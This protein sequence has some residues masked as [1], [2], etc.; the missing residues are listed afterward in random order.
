MER[1]LRLSRSRVPAFVLAGGTFGVLFAHIVQWYESTISYALVVD[2]KPFNSPE[3]FVPID[4]ETLILYAAIGAVLGMLFLNGLPGFTIRSSGASRRTGHQRRVLPFRRVAG[5][6]VRQDYD[7]E[8]LA[9]LGG[10]EVQFL[11]V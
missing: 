10:T 5:R 11:K 1:A 4:F 2:G 7:P 6:D 9:G 3:A 8:L